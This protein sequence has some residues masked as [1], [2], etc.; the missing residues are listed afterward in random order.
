MW[1]GWRDCG[2]VPDFPDPSGQNR[3][4]RGSNPGTPWVDGG[5]D[6]DDKG[7]WNGV[8]YYR[9]A[10]RLADIIDGTSNTIMAY[11]DM[12]WIGV[13]SNGRLDRTYTHDSA[14]MSPLAALGNLRNPINNKNPAWNNYDSSGGEPRC[15]GWSSDHPGGAQC[16]MADAT[17]KFYSQDIAPIVKYALATRNGGEDSANQ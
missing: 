9:S 5:W 2:N 8:F 4:G 7:R 12:H 14:W 11:E 1:G 6:S 15:H 3:M 17:V 16:V 10:A 13:D